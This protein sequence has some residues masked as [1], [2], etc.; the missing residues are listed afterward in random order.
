MFKTNFDNIHCIHGYIR[1]FKENMQNTKLE[2]Y[3]MQHA[4]LQTNMAKGIAIHS[5]DLDLARE[6]I[7]ESGTVEWALNYQCP[8]P[9]S[10]SIT[11][12][13]PPRSFL[14]HSSP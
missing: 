2:H 3:Y 7:G 8:H 11:P 10:P 5:L 1:N 4:P 12:C 13:T 6:V 14:E 9:S